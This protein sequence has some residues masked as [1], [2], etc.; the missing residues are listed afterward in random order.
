M[1]WARTPG[2]RLTME[3]PAQTTVGPQPKALPRAQ[4]FAV[5]FS[6][7]VMERVRLPD[8]RLPAELFTTRPSASFLLPMLASISLPICV[9]DGFEC[10]TLLTIRPARLLPAYRRR[11]I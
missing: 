2:K 8:A 10:L 1:T 7:T 9:A 3:S 4:I 5:H 11:S 6:V